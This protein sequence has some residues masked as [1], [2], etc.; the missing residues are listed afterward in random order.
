M[1][2]KTVLQTPAALLILAILAVGLVVWLGADVLL[3]VV[4]V[5]PFIVCVW[6]VRNR[7]LTLLREAIQ[8]D[9]RKRKPLIIQHKEL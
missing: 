8:G 2:L 7:H 1:S 4:V 3:G 9:M 6:W 5:V